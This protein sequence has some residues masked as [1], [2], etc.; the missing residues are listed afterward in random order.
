MNKDLIYKYVTPYLNTNK[1]LTWDEF[2]EIFGEFTTTQE[3]Y[4]ISRIIEEELDVNFVDEKSTTEKL[5]EN[6]ND[7]DKETTSF[8]YGYKYSTNED[9]IQRYHATK[10]SFILDDLIKRNE[11]FIRKQINDVSKKYSHDLE[12]D[13]LYQ[14]ACEGFIK[15]CKKFDYSKGAK[16]LTYT[17]WW[18]IQS[19]RRKIEEEGFKVKLP[20]HVWNEITKIRKLEAQ[21]PD[22]NIEDLLKQEN[23]KKDRYLKLKELEK[24]Y[25]SQ[26]FL[27]STINNTEGVTLIDSLSD[28]NYEVFSS[29]KPEHIDKTTDQELLK[30]ALEEVLKELSP[31]ERDIIRLRF[32]FDDKRQ[33]TLEEIGQLFNVTR[34]RI[35]QVEAKALKKLRKPDRIKRLEEYTEN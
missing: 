6:E 33:R 23:I 12:E 14:I 1:E 15:G 17:G 9:L 11:K 16:L 10:Y 18:V 19:L 30:E 3:Q 31:R 21:N 26:L 27:D 29:Q 24:N 8:S 28:E 5:I 13:D 35:R 34:E 2:D 25:L 7:T 22:T 20:T 32:G 4:E